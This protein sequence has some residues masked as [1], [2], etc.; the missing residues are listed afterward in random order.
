MGVQSALVAGSLAGG[1]VEREMAVKFVLVL[2]RGAPCKSPSDQGAGAQRRLAGEAVWRDG[3]DGLWSG[4][5]G[6]TL[7]GPTAERKR[8]ASRGRQTA[9]L[10]WAGT[11]HCWIGGRTFE[12]KPGTSPPAQGVLTG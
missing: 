4:C 12:A 11:A 7:C 6:G 5:I 1:Q 9:S 8:P 3:D 10:A 2:M